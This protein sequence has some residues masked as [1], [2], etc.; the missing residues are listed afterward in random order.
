MKY[1]DIEPLEL[2]NY[3]V[4]TRGRQV[5]FVAV[6]PGDLGEP[7]VYENSEA[8]CQFATLRAAV[9]SLIDLSKSQR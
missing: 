4:S 5:G 8:L 2:E 6:V 1:V 9:R 3:R 7:A